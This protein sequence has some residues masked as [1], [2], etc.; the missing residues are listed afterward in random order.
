VDSRAI[1]LSLYFCPTVKLG[2]GS[3]Y[4]GTFPDHSGKPL[5][6]GN[7]YRLHVPAEVPVREFCL[8]PSIV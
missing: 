1:A 8:P 6:G 7:N 4:F 3:F 2:S 5:E